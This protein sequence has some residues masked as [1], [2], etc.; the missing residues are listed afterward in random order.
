MEQN[1]AKTAVIT[2]ASSGLGR[3]YVKQ[4]IKS[5]PEITDFWLIARRYD[6]MKELAYEF[7]GKKFNILALDLSNPESF[8]EYKKQLEEYKPDIKLL[9]NNSGYGKLGFFNEL[10]VDEQTGMIDVNIRALTAV[11]R[12]SLEY[13]H[14]G[15]VILNVCSIAAFIPNPR[16]AVYCSTKAF[17]FSFSKALREELKAKNINVLAACPGPMDTEFLSVANIPQGASKLF[18]FCPRVNPSVMA[19]KSLKYAFNGKAVYTNKFI[20]KLYRVICKLLPHNWLMK[21]FTA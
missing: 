9:I 10:G 7:Q 1:S 19:E 17:V 15:S 14:S 3:E 18:D 8:A 12:L 5:H 16:M 6:K 20:Y 13:M 21:K 11:T 2:G 4:V